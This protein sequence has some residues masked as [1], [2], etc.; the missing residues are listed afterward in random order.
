MV[1]YTSLCSNSE[2]YV[3]LFPITETLLKGQERKC[4]DGHE[5]S[6]IVERRDLQ[7]PEG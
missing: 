5:L 4:N 6:G 2:L 7:F 1:V 3:K